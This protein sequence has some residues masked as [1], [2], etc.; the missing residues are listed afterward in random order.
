MKCPACLKDN[1]N[2]ADRCACGHDFSR[3]TRPQATSQPGRSSPIRGAL[4]GALV[5]A[6][7]RPLVVVSVLFYLRA[8]DAPFVRGTPETQNYYL[9]IF[10][11]ASACLGLLIGA[12][13]GATCRLGLGALIGAGMSGASCLCLVVLPGNAM[14]A[15]SGGGRIDYSKEQMATIVGLLAMIVVGAIAGGVGGAAGKWR[16]GNAIQGPQAEN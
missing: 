12:F 11:I 4:M 1:K 14:I 8:E 7:G 16:R 3:N 6:I 2:D 9:L 10:S 5:G 15:M 13:A